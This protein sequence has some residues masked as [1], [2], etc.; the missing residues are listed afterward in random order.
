[1]LRAGSGGRTGSGGVK[2]PASGLGAGPWPAGDAAPAAGGVAAGGAVAEE[3]ALA[4]VRRLLAG[5]APELLAALDERV[6]GDGEEDE[7]G[8]G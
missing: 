2:Q 5:R 4:T 7:G 8:P 6:L 3:D 1:M